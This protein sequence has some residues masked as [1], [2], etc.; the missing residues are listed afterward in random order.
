ME[1]MLKW[2]HHAAV[3]LQ[4]GVQ[5]CLPVMQR[6]SALLER[7]DTI[8]DCTMKPLVP[9][10]P[11]CDAMKVK[12]CCVGRCRGRRRAAEQ[13]RPWLR[14]AVPKRDS[15]KAGLNYSSLSVF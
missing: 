12:V 14:A 11:A 13:G 8:K 2:K 5:Q 3:M 15:L 6:M 10:G 4:H 1:S 9:A 7:P